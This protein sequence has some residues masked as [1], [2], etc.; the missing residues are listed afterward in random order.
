MNAGK[1]RLPYMKKI[2]YFSRNVLSFVYV[3]LIH[4]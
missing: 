1:R 2:K 3:S 4:V